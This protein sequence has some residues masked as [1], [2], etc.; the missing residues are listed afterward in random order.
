MSI[1][2]TPVRRYP[3]QLTTTKTSAPASY[4]RTI[5][6]ST[7]HSRFGQSSQKQTS[8]YEAAQETIRKKSNQVLIK[9]VETTCP[10]Y[11]S[12]KYTFPSDQLRINYQAPPCKGANKLRLQ[13]SAIRG[14]R[15][16]SL[17][18]CK[19]PDLGPPLTAQDQYGC[20]MFQPEYAYFCATDATADDKKA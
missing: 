11:K 1:S 13:Y 3:V 4:F 19:D 5:S 12:G 17:F 20:S 18:D 6:P 9:K 10:K 15:N 7:P 16:I 8:E 2:F 14:N